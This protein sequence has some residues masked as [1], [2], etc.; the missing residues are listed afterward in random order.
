LL[1]IAVIMA[2]CAGIEPFEPRNHREEGPEKGL[3][4]GSEGEFVILRKA[5]EPEEDSEDKKSLK[6]TESAAQPE[7]DSEQSGNVE[8]HPGDTP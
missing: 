5:E 2:G 8:E 3:F 4:T 7:A 1:L 6:E